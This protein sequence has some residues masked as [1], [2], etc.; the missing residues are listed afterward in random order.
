MMQRRILLLILGLLLAAGEAPRIQLRYQPAPKSTWLTEGRLTVKTW[1]RLPSGEESSTQEEDEI[2]W[3]DVVT[4]RDLV[5]S[6]AQTR[7]V[8]RWVR[9]GTQED[10]TPRDSLNYTV[11]KLAEQNHQGLL[12]QPALYPV[13]SVAVG[14]VWPIESTRRGVV[15][16]NGHPLNLTTRVEGTGRL[17]RVDPQRAWIEVALTMESTGQ[18]PGLSSRALSQVRWT[19]EVERAEGVPVAQKTETTT[20][21]TVTIGS[22]AIPSRSETV[23]ELTTHRVSLSKEDESCDAL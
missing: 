12:D 1:M 7:T 18:G 23:L 9:R 11:T 4:G 15:S 20:E 14:E 13:R 8:T 2:A 6:L 10:L 21:Q 3:T 5:G 16:L 22:V 17:V 19:L